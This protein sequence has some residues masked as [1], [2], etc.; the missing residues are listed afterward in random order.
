MMMDHSAMI[1]NRRSVRAFRDKPVSADVV[2]R[3]LEYYR[4][5]CQRLIPE[6]ETELIVMD[7]E[8]QAALEGTAG[9]QQ[10]LIGSPHYLMLLS[11]RHPHA[12]ENA[13]YVMEDL[14]LKLTELDVDSCWLT[15]TEGE[16][17]KSTLSLASP[18]EL[19]A[20]VA[21]GYGVKLGKR[22]RLNI[23]SMSDVDVYAVQQYYAPKKSLRELVSVG[24]W[25]EREGLEE[26]LGFYEDMLFQAFYA[27]SLSPSYLNRQ[28]Y[29]FLVRGHEV[30][31]IQTRDDHTDE[32]DGRLDLGIVLLHFSAVVAQW[33]GPVRWELDELDVDVALPEGCRVVGIYH[34]PA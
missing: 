8:I 12:V 2:E 28:P 5:E 20:I 24:E 21:F 15:F 9:Y 26:L 22:L 14:V 27:A 17:I 23:R 34:L 7:A 13:G 32:F 16:E 33:V 6:I 29:G 4:T 18:K 31:L 25:G 10:F 3:L 11:D 30:M 1:Q 19:V